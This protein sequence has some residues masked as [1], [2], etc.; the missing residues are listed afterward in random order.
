MMYSTFSHPHLSYNSNWMALLSSVVA[1]VY[2]GHILYMYTCTGKITVDMSFTST[3]QL[4]FF[5]TQWSVS[6]RAD[7][8][9]VSSIT[10]HGVITYPHQLSV[11]TIN[12]FTHNLHQKQINTSSV[13]ATS[14]PLLLR[15]TVLWSEM[16]KQ[17]HNKASSCKSADV[18]WMETPSLQY[19]Q[20]VH[21][22]ILCVE[23]LCSV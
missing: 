16:G 7:A 1:L 13:T 10:L 4:N 9:N 11:D 5:G 18:S 22:L 12:C 14:I 19:G 3:V 6:Q 20:N 2:V 8:W 23:Q 21:Q 17:T 15:Y